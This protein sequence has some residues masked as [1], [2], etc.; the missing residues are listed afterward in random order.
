LE[1]SRYTR[2]LTQTHGIG[3]HIVKSVNLNV[4]CNVTL[5]MFIQSVMK[6]VT[7]GHRGS[8]IATST[9]LIKRHEDR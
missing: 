5:L 8:Y 2:L 1:E 3:S 4:Y 7:D 6:S 9:S